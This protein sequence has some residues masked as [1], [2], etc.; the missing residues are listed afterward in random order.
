MYEELRMTEEDEENEESHYII[1]KFPY[2]GDKA[3]VLLE[4]TVQGW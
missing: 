3:E 4:L 2:D 1:W